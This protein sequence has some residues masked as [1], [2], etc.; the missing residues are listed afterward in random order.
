MSQKKEKRNVVFRRIGGRIVPIAVGAGA[1]GAGMAA[2]SKRARKAIDKAD[3]KLARNVA[4]G[5]RGQ[6]LVKWNT[7]NQQIARQNRKYNKVLSKAYGVK[8]GQV[9]DG[10]KTI[11]FDPLKKWNLH[12]PFAHLARI[13]GA[14]KASFADINTNVKNTPLMLHELAHRE[15]YVK[16]KTVFKGKAWDRISKTYEKSLF[17]SIN[18]K[19]RGVEPSHKDYQYFK[20][21]VKL[22]KA[23]R[24]LAKRISVAAQSAFHKSRYKALGVA[25]D[26]KRIGME[27]EA[28]AKAVKM[29]YKLRGKK[30]AV[31][32]AKAMIPN[33]TS[34]LK[35]PAIK[36]TK[37]GLIGAGAVIIGKSLLDK[38]KRRKK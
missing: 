22:D 36:L 3:E 6:R 24:K 13:G 7:G 21:N 33:V 8:P 15:Q 38:P 30:F 17:K 25:I 10:G 2:G 1:V 19:H 31:I 37:Y 26:A 35:G 18:L 28:N 9:Y 32:T 29:A 5:K 34:N 23:K 27:L 16:G 20:G 14:G 12:S 11:K 4:A